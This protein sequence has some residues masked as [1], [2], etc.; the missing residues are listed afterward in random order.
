MEERCEMKEKILKAYEASKEVSI[1]ECKKYMEKLKGNEDEYELRLAIRDTD[2]M[3]SELQGMLILLRASEVISYGKYKKERE[4][5]NEA[6]STRQLYG[7][8][9]MI[10]DGTL[11]KNLLA[12]K[13]D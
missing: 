4:E 13:E 3:K 12:K 9:V 11:V 8:F 5:L 10:H 2:K 1:Q 6:F 7:A